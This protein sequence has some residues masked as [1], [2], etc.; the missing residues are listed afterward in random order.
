MQRYERICSTC[1][2]QCVAAA[3]DRPR[4][5]RDRHIPQSLGI[6]SHVPRDSLEHEY[7]QL[8]WS[9]RQREMFIKRFAT[10]RDESM[11]VHLIEQYLEGSGNKH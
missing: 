2:S 9:Q 1:V 6:G 8:L 3:C 10:G 4:G 7:P 11:S 5:H